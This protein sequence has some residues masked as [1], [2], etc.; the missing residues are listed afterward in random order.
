MVSRDSGRV[1]YSFAGLVGHAFTQRSLGAG[2]AYIYL[3]I[4]SLLKTVFQIFLVTLP[5]QSHPQ[6]R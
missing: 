1:N 4:P 6:S 2:S 3:Y 5:T